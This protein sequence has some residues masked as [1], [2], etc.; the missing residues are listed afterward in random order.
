MNCS[1]TLKNLR[2]HRLQRL[3]GNSA[4]R[5]R[6]RCCSGPPLGRS[7]SS[8]WKPS[9]TVGLPNH[10]LRSRLVQFDCG[11]RSLRVIHWRDARVTPSNCKS[12]VKPPS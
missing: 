1:E 3:C 11:K 5:R 8:P 9:L 4:F 12:T 2:G 10:Y 7:L 6:R